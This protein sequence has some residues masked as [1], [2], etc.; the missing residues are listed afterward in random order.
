MKDNLL[1]RIVFSAVASCVVSGVIFLF[2]YPKGISG[3]LLTGLATAMN[4]AV[5]FLNYRRLQKA[6]RQGGRKV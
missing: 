1:T 4:V 6:Q 5:A 3:L 2:L